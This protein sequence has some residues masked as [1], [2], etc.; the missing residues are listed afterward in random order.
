VKLVIFGL[1]ISSAWGNGHATLWRGLCRALTARGHQ[2]TFFER[3]VPYYAAH[4]DSIDASICKLRLYLHWAEV[5]G[6]AAQECAEADVAMV[7]S[8]CADGSAAADLVLNSG[9]ALR[10]FYDLDT[11]VTLA[12]LDKGEHVPY[13]PVDGLADFDLVLSYTGGRALTELRVRL[14]ARQVAPLY[15]S[16]D[17]DAHHRLEPSRARRADLSYLGTYAADRQE[18]LEA[19]FV[20]PARRSPSRRF[21]IGGSQYPDDFPWT[22]NMYYVR[23]MP[24]PDHPAFYAA[25]RLTLNVTRGAMA[26]MGFCP[27]GRLFEAAACGTPILSDAWEGLDSFFEPQ[28]EI[29]LAQTADEALEAIR[30]S[31]DELLRIARAA[32][33]RT[34]EEHTAATRASELERILAHAAAPASLSDLVSSPE[35]AA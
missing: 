30:L 31:D 27:S 9:A 23:H 1:T 7:T 18:R 14:G 16:V 34:L 4:R 19:L 11:P 10:V 25:S 26:E 13:L 6:F 15:G 29:L 20:E 12:K 21:V 24:P 33:E 28:R 17:P 2:V 22:P 5:L 8:Y 3:D 35:S 32:R